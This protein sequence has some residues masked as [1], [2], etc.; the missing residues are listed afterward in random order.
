MGFPA[1]QRLQIK[2]VASDRALAAYRETVDITR[3][4]LGPFMNRVESELRFGRTE[5]LDV[6]W[7][8]VV[9]ILFADEVSEFAPCKVNLER[10]SLI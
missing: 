9:T 4:N 10:Q 7:F 6:Q 2:L 5:V 3:G 8:K 1:L